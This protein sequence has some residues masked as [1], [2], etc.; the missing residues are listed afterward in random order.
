VQLNGGG[1]G[2][3]EDVPV[4]AIKACGGVEVYSSSFLNG[5]GQLHAWLL[6]AQGKS[7]QY[8]TE[9]EAVWAPELAWMLWRREKFF[10]PTRN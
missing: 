6:H 4:H 8:P 10:V 2:Q 7:L 3:L 1:T 5:S 9:Q